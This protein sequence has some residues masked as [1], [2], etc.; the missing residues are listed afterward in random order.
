MDYMRAVLVVS[1]AG[2]GLQRHSFSIPNPPSASSCCLG[3]LTHLCHMA[4]HHMTQ[5]PASSTKKRM[6]QAIRTHRRRGGLWGPFHSLVLSLNQTSLRSPPSINTS[7]AVLP[8]QL[9]VQAS[10]LPPAPHPRGRTNLVCQAH[11]FAGP[12][13]ASASFFL[14]A[15]TQHQPAPALLL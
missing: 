1:W 9:L 8:Y 7:Q 14:A 6:D 13:V 11:L 10:S 12:L 2:G 15:K 4:E 3:T 5:R